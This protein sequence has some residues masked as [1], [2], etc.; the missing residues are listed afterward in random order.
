[1]DGNEPVIRY[2]DTPLM[3]DNALGELIESDKV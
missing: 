1:M 2:F 3:V